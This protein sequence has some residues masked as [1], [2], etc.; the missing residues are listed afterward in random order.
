[1]HQVTS[2]SD[3]IVY[4]E[5]Y[6]WRV[7]NA[8]WHDRKHGEWYDVDVYK[9]NDVG[10]AYSQNLYTSMWGSYA[11]AFPGLPINDKSYWY[12]NPDIAALEGWHQRYFGSRSAG[13]VPF[14]TGFRHLR[15]TAQ[16]A[17]SPDHQ[18]PADR[19]CP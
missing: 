9:E 3:R 10:E 13:Q 15:N 19:R 2:W 16:N 11:V 7:L 5:G 14:P 6:I 8:S 12:Y 17:Y 18:M 4:E 1:M